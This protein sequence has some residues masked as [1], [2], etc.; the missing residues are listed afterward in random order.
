MQPAE[1][2]RIHTFLATSDLHLSAKLR[3][4]RNEC[5]DSAVSAAVL[6]ESDTTAKPRAC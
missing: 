6:V 3:I 1:R 4:T 5:L 2:S